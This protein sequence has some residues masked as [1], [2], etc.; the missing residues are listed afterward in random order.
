M[1]IILETAM[2]INNGLTLLHLLIQSNERG[3][4][5]G[6]LGLTTQLQ[7]RGSEWSSQV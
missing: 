6:Y 5:G 2:Q 3:E 7:Q 4:A 1:V